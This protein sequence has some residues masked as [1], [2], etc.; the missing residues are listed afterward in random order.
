MQD[1]DISENPIDSGRTRIV[2][3]YYL[4][5]PTASEAAMQACQGNLLQ[6]LIFC[7]HAL[8][9]STGGK[10]PLYIDICGIQ[11]QWRTRSKP[12]VMS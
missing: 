4:P 1:S 8:D 9:S 3:E 11:T 5:T 10:A 12:D 7:G 2:L 6:I